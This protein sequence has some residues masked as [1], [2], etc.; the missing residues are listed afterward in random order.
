MNE[1]TTCYVA[2]WQDRHS[3]TGV[4]VFSDKMA[5]I[6]WARKTAREYDREGGLSEKM[7]TAMIRAGWIYYGVYSC[8][9]DSIRVEEC[10]VD[11]KIY[12]G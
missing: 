12:E 3:D 5:A 4:Y 6:E 8:E 1:L 2:V 10:Q 11:K 9:G 7:N